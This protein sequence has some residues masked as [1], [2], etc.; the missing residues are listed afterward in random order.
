[1]CGGT[2]GDESVSVCQYV[3]SGGGGAAARSLPRA[4]VSMITTERAGTWYLKATRDLLP[5]HPAL[6]TLRVQISVV[7]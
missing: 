6:T 7:L 5:T 2:T 1:M 3:W 4:L